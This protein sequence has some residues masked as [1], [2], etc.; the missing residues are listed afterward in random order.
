[1]LA[2]T[3]P[4]VRDPNDGAA[5]RADLEHGV[6]TVVQVLTPEEAIMF[7]EKVVRVMT[8]V[9]A[10]GQTPHGAKGCG[11]VGCYGAAQQEDVWVLRLNERLRTAMETIY[12]TPDLAVSC[13][14]VFYWGADGG[15]EST[16]RTQRATSPRKLVQQRLGSTLCLH[17][18]KGL[19]SYGARFEQGLR[20]SN[21]LAYHRSLQAQITLTPVTATSAGLVLV[22]GPMD[23]TDDEQAVLFTGLD[24]DFCCCTDEAYDRFKDRLVKVCVPAGCAIIWRSDRVHAN[25][26]ADRDCDPRRVGLFVTWHPRAHAY[27]RDKKMAFVMEG[28]T[29]CHWPLILT[30]WTR[31]SSHMSNR[32]GESK[33]LTPHFSEELR[34]KIW[35]AV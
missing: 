17:K 7:R 29:G 6:C 33:P 11:F 25:C 32:H 19:T 14:N 22:D 1:M 34:A 9:R 12:G 35:H 16:P 10:S 3:T 13:D 8:Q 27:D 30:R 4:V 24:G 26:K 28:R 23:F 21:E 2:T 20:A 15:R 5:M 18:D 31:S